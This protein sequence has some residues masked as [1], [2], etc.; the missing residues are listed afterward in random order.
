MERVGL[1]PFSQKPAIGSYS[2]PAQLILR[3]ILILSFHVYRGL[4]SGIFP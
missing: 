2:E 4:Q 1:A 3:S